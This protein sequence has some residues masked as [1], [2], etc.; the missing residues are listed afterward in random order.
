MA[1]LALNATTALSN[2]DDEALQPGPA[3]ALVKKMLQRKFAASPL[4]LNVR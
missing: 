4:L 3:Q 2:V 1:A